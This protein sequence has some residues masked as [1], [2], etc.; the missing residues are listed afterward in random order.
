MADDK[1]DEQ[2]D[3]GST[4]G[5]VTEREELL[6][7][8]GSKPVLVA[9]KVVV[10]E[11]ETK[12]EGKETKEEVESEEETKTE[13]KEET[14]TEEE[15]KLTEKGTKLDPNPQSA[16]H[17]ELAN[18]RKVRSDL[19]TKT[20]NYERVLADPK[21]LAQ[22]AKQQYGLEV[23]VE[24]VKPVEEVPAYKAEDF[25]SLEDVAKVVNGLQKNLLD[26]T[27]SYEEEIQSLKQN[28]NNLL[29]GGKQQQIANTLTHEIGNLQKLPELT[30]TNSDYIEGLEQ[31]IVNEYDRLD[32]DKEVEIDNG[33]GKEP[34]K[35]RV[36]KGNYSI[37]EIAER[38]VAE[39]KTFMKSGSIKAQTIVKDKTQG[40][41]VTNQANTEELDTK[42]LSPADS[43]ALGI[44][45]MKF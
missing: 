23:P 19:E 36:Y 27:K 28:V 31:A 32:F 44:S 41:V 33:P 12:V 2:I 22:F 1:T 25:E 29:Q 17:Q 7:E 43:M 11:P 40:K 13:T 15:P 42:D 45:K 3:G 6:N 14:K 4:F 30:P 9:D 5:E 16:V 21:L 20:K 10:A 35:I 34:T 18:E 39:A 38:K 26:K 8:D 37:A 24:P